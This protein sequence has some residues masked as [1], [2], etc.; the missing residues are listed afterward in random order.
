ML[1]EALGALQL[2]KNMIPIPPPW[3]KPGLASQRLLLCSKIIPTRFG[4]ERHPALRVNGMANEWPNVPVR[5]LN[6]LQSAVVCRAN[7]PMEIV[8]DIVLDVLVYLE[9]RTLND[10]QFSEHVVQN[11]VACILRAVEHLQAQFVL[12]VPVV[13]LS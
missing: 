3:P 1:S 5:R 2:L 9:V 10:R 7:H 4:A 13:I 12:V 6:K 8:G 11:D